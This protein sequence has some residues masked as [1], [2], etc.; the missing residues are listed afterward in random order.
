MNKLYYLI[1][2]LSLIIIYFNSCSNN[3][4]YSENT[5]RV[6]LADIPSLGG[7]SWFAARYQDYQPKSDV[8]TAISQT[9]DR[10]HHKFYVF[11][12]P[13]CSCEPSQSRFPYCLKVLTEAGIDTSYI[14][15]YSML[16]TSSI[17]PYCSIII[18]RDL[19]SMFIIKDG[20]PVYSVIDSLLFYQRN[21]DTVLLVEDFILRG[22]QK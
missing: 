21:I 2:I 20:V 14:E 7:Y 12:K 4:A 9:F 6:S 8:I 22:L 3:S 5:L 11:G 15:I 16:R 10:T 17:H 19:P 13:A 18:I 1:I